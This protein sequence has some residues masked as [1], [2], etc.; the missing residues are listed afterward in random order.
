MGTH[1]RDI[2]VMGQPDLTYQEYASIYNILSFV[3]ASMGACTIFF[4]ARLSSF[5]EKYK[6]AL[7]FTGLVTLIACYHYFRIFNSFVDSYV[8]KAG[9]TEDGY[10]YEAANYNCGY[11]ASGK[12]FN[13]A[14]RYMDWLLT[15]PLLLIEIVLVMQLSP[16]ET[17]NKAANLGCSSA[18]MIILGYPGEV[19]DSNATRWIFW[20]LAMIPFIFIVYTLVIGL[21]S[22]A[23]K[24]ERED[25]ALLCKQAC[26]WTV[27]SWCTYPIVYILPML[28]GH[29]NGEMSASNVVGIQ[30]GYSIADVISKCGV[31]LLVYNIGIRKSNYEYA[32]KRDGLVS[33]ETQDFRAAMAK[34]KAHSYDAVPTGPSIELSN[35]GR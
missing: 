30:I 27:G 31:G 10:K 7:C 29:S 15:V 6:T 9:C 21:A 17:F 22:A 14:Y 11:T 1:E 20:A 25:V 23:D 12:Y 33:E 24:D 3:I 35:R 19:S 34:A 16:H 18:I 5:H 26:W 2:S 28:M 13:D 4:F 32:A 8:E